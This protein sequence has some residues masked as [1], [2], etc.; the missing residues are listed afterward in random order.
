MAITSSTVFDR[1]YFVA[2]LLIGDPPRFNG[3]WL[4]QGSAI[5]AALDPLR[6]DNPE[7]GY[8]EDSAEV[9]IIEDAISSGSAEFRYYD[10]EADIA[11]EKDDVPASLEW[12]IRRNF[13]QA[14][15]DREQEIEATEVFPAT[16]L[17]FKVQATAPTGTPPLFSAINNTWSR[18][19]AAI[20]AAG[21]SVDIPTSV[22]SGE[23]AW[24]TMASY[25][26]VDGMYECFYD[27]WTTAST[28][29]SFDNGVT[30]LVDPSGLSNERMSFVTHI[31]RYNAV[32]RRWEETENSPQHQQEGGSV[33]FKSADYSTPWH[34][35]YGHA[36]M[37]REIPLAV[38]VGN[39]IKL[40]IELRQATQWFSTGQTPK[41]EKSAAVELMIESIELVAPHEIADDNPVIPHDQ[42][43]YML[44]M[45]PGG[46]LAIA[47]IDSEAILNDY[48]GDH[49]RL[50]LFFK[51]NPHAVLQ[52]AID[53]DDT[54]LRY[55]NKPNG[56][57]SQG[58]G[59]QQLYITHGD[60]QDSVPLQSVDR[61]E[62]TATAEEGGYK[63]YDVTVS[64]RD[65][66]S[67]PAGSI[68]TVD[69]NRIIYRDM[70]ISAKRNLHA[71]SQIRVYRILDQ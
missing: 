8:D 35:I 64:G 24:K 70:V 52:K 66:R 65:G 53:G 44:A 61:T 21:Y 34:Y 26:Y 20:E 19:K 1:V 9:G 40:G 4:M 22:P 67:Y 29:Y 25:S 56:L 49:H 15:I 71:G 12:L 13:I 7:S 51:S 55:S 43:T 45:S 50:T 28:R 57:I 17:V 33:E 46:G 14:R 62:R 16:A 63:Y 58:S 30:W 23:F 10:Q 5:V 18:W 3:I 32:R 31:Q 60:Q 38:D 48:L 59:L 2:S 11:Y 54:V 42:K 41:F 69:S 37:P 27:G 39:T 36:D 6:D 47:K 68:I